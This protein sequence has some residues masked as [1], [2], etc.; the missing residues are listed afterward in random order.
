[1]HEVD[2]RELAL[3]LRAGV[4]LDRTRTIMKLREFMPNNVRYLSLTGVIALLAAGCEGPEPPE[5]AVSS[6]TQEALTGIDALWEAE[7]PTPTQ[8]AQ[9]EN[10]SPNNSVAGAIHTIVTHPTDANIIYA[11]GVNGGIWRTNDAT[12][13]TPTWTPLTDFFQSISV[14]ALAMDPTDSDVLIAGIGNYSS[15]LQSG[16]LTGL[17]LSTDAGANWTQLTDPLLPARSYSGVTARGNFMLASSNSAVLRSTDGGA[18]WAILS[19]APGTGLPFGAAFDLVS[20]PSDGSRYYV[21]IGGQG[22]FRSNDDGATWVNVS[23]NDP[24]GL[25][26]ALASFGANNAEM[27]VGTDGLLFVTVVNAGQP[28]FIGFSPNQGTTWTPM[29]LPNFPQTGVITNI[30]N[31][32]N[33]TPIVITLAANHGLPQFEPG[34]SANIS[35]VLGNTAANGTFQLAT[36]VPAA[37][38]NQF[39]LLGSSGNGAYAG[40][41]SWQAFSGVSPRPKP[42]SQGAI[43]LS[44]AVHPADSTMV[45]LCGDRQVL[46]SFVG[47]TEFSAACVRGDTTI[48]ATG[49][50]PSPQWEHLG[51]SNAIAAVPGG[52]TASSSASHA[53][54]REM[55]FDANGD[56]IESDDGGINRR[57]NPGDNTGDWT[58]IVGNLQVAEFHAIAYDANS[59]VVFG[60]AQ[61][62]GVP[63]QIT[64]GSPTWT[65]LTTADGGDVQVDV[66]TSPGQSIRYFSNQFL[67][68][69]RRVTFD[70]ASNAVATTF[71]GLNP[72][73]SVQAQFYTPIELNK[74]TP[75]R[76]AIAGANAVFES[77][78]QGD[79]VTSLGAGG[80]A[81]GMAY[82][83]PDNVEAL[84]VAGFFGVLV[85]TTAGGALA[86]TTFPGAATDVTMD[87]ADF[88]HAFAISASQVF[89]TTDAG[90]TW[91]DVT[92]DLD[93][94]APGQLRQVLY[95]PGGTVDK[96]VVA[97][98]LGV[99]VSA[100]NAPG[101][102]NELGS[103]LPNAPA[104]D[105]DFDAARDFLL[106]GT[107]GRGAFSLSPFTTVDLPPAAICQNVTVPANAQCQGSASAAQVD[108]GSFDPDG[109]PVSLN[110]VPPGPF[111][112][113]P[114]N[115]TL[116]VTDAAGQTETCTAVVTV[117]D[118]TPPVLNCPVSVNVNCVNANGAT[119]SFATSAADNCGA[120]ATP[121]CAP[122][123]GSNFP[124]G[125]TVDVCTSADASGNVGSC[126]F[127]VTVAIADNPVCCPAG[128]NVML[129]NSNNN[130]LNGTSG[131]DCILGRGAQDI[132]NGNGGNDFLSGGDGDDT[133]NCG[134]GNDLAFGG[135]GQDLMNGGDG[136]DVMSGG[137]GDD[138]CNGGDGNDTLLGAQG[139]DALNGNA[140]LDTLVG[141]TGDDR[142]DGGSG[143]DALIGGGLHDIC[144]GGPGTDTFLTCENQ[145]Q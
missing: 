9:V 59:Q 51:H 12:S 11:S 109:G 126:S 32:S 19:G 90:G 82:G 39:T 62:T 135:T 138:T 41:G 66:A 22:L 129:G 103:N 89:E 27:A 93:E 18:T 64:G 76:I 145:T 139:Q 130:T 92:G 23:Q 112:L 110:L 24:A 13:V 3:V 42:G 137:D 104:M 61:D 71:I 141:E 75:T 17:L 15:F 49:A 14:T 43:H 122:P 6:R 26:P 97:S 28:V 63:A 144:V 48:A 134:L 117:I 113:G 30:V 16:A 65:S 33:T 88:N 34:L 123:S 72:P 73:N 128:T 120:A 111:V 85:R 136:N 143:D 60:G 124:L 35:G 102:W 8:N 86:A 38:P 70:A 68:N 20:D 87:P 98:N 106:V 95:V 81:T 46:P 36:I 115:V 29:D 50:I 132:I 69:F 5:E 74:N 56:L 4:G 96:V 94:L 125:T 108:G 44:V 119:A 131:S 142:L 100:D 78:D 67:I 40:G 31:A 83:N 127:N 53:D 114:N 37:P 58:S 121:V 133:I 55:A 79:N 52:G 77:F 45:F 54:S 91:T 10:L 99:F 25:Q 1:L 2:A 116:E 118:V 105:L 7:G 21:T 140:G 84:Y 80:S 101:F 57:T 107:L 47:A